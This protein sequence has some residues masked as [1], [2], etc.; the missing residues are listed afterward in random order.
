ML[1][2]VMDQKPNVR[3]DDIAGETVLPVALPVS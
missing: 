3:W 2:E 1:R